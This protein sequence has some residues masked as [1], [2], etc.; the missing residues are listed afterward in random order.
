M[1]RFH[2]STM[3]SSD[4][5]SDDAGDVLR[6]AGFDGSTSL[7]PVAAAAADSA[8]VSAS[9]SAFLSQKLRDKTVC[10]RLPSS[11]AA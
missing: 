3:L 6:S 10:E 11:A 7:P 4:D 2:W 8:T 1:L 9:S 5:A